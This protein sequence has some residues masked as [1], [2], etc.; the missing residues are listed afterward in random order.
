MYLAV[1]DD[2]VALAAAASSEIE[3]NPDVFKFRWYHKLE[4]NQR[5]IRYERIA[6]VS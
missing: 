4:S 2:V 6:L 3:K 1:A 5:P